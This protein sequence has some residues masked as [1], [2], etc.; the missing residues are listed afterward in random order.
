MTTT[1]PTQRQ[2][3]LNGEGDAWYHRNC[4]ISTEEKEHWQAQDPLAGFLTELPLPQGADISVLEVGCGQG[5]RLLRMQQEF[6]WQVVGVDPSA[7]AVAQVVAAGLEAHVATADSLP[8]ADASVDLLIYGFCLY[9]CDRSDLCKI[10]AEAHRVLKPESWLAI[11]DFWSPHQTVNAY[12]HRPGVFSFK[13][14]LPSMF[15]WHPS[16]VV[17]DHRLRH[18]ATRAY[19]DDPQ[20]WIAAT[21]LRRCDRAPSTGHV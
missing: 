4:Q 8:L 18:H 7:E 15:S 20:E 6:G 3:F 2:V 1:P 19:T 5:L 12:H 13:D 10:V 11:L 21:I 16:Y 14:N 9:L 17:T